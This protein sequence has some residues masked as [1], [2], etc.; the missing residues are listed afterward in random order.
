MAQILEQENNKSDSDEQSNDTQILSL[1]YLISLMCLSQVHQLGGPRKFYIPGETV[2]LDR[3][4]QKSIE[5]GLF[6]LLIYI[7]TQLKNT[8]FK[9]LIDKDFWNLLEEEDY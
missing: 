8:E 2:E 3:L 5:Y 6:T 7:D 4:K 1:K 9:Q